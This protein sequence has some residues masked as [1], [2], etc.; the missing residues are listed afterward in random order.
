MEI[1]EK[2]FYLY[3]ISLTSLTWSIRRLIPK[4]RTTRRFKITKEGVTRFITH[5]D[6]KIPKNAV[7]KFAYSG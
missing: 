6:I 3:R 4:V 2:I 7:T 1:L 5:I